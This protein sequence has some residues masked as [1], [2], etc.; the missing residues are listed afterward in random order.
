M[1]GEDSV[2]QKCDAQL[3]LAEVGRLAKW[4]NQAEARIR[5]ATDKEVE[6]EGIRGGGVMLKKIR[7]HPFSGKMLDCGQFRRHFE[8]LTG[9]E[10][11]LD[12]A[13]IAHLALKG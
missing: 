8:S 7:I 9:P 6:V 5:D 3:R 12:W 10:K 11:L 13:T 1:D 4:T 2:R